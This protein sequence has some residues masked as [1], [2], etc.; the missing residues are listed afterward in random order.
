MA[1]MRSER[2]KGYKKQTVVEALVEQLIDEIVEGRYR[3][4]ERLPPESRMCER[5]GVSHQVIREVVRMLAAR[6]VVEVRHGKGAFVTESPT[7]AM[8]EALLTALRRNHAT[9]WEVEE[10]FQTVLPSVL[11]LAVERATPED[12]Q[13]LTA[14]VER[15]L[16]LLEEVNVRGEVAEKHLN[17]LR[18]RFS[19]IMTAIAE[20]SHNAVIALFIPVLAAVHS[21]R[22]WRDEDPPAPPQWVVSVERRHFTSLI[23]ALSARDRSLLEPF[24]TRFFAL[25]PEAR[26]A[27][28]ATPVGK[29]VWIPLPFELG[30][31]D[32]DSQ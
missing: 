15:Y 3:A 7:E 12:V 24:L 2:T 23:A 13:R 4:G 11:R 6:G 29:A 9:V 30:M 20:A 27:M 14:A 16:T 17:E 5:F 28:E 18:Y 26:A 1:E 8:G 31:G 22:R 21:V 25:S 32:T 10:C 19:C